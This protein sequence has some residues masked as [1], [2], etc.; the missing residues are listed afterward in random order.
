MRW[1]SASP[2]L[3]PPPPLR[4]R[5]TQ[6]GQGGRPTPFDSGGGGFRHATTT[7]TANSISLQ[8]APIPIC[9]ARPGPSQAASR[10]GPPTGRQQAAKPRHDK[11]RRPGHTLGDARRE[12]TIFC[13]C[14]V[15][16][17]TAVCEYN[18]IAQR[19][20]VGTGRGE[21]HGRVA[22]R[23]AGP[24]ERSLLCR[25]RDHRTVTVTVKQS[26]FFLFFSRKNNIPKVDCYRK[27]CYLPLAASSA[28]SA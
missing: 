23:E 4:R 11:G 15:G 8:L 20:S 21:E 17:V 5:L 3:A 14:A 2:R 22:L 12:D 7:T 24:E 16:C 27:L 10:A 6:R 18:I 13:R 9:I 26:P 19:G 1:L 25:I 28:R